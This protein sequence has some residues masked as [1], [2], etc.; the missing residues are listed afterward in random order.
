MRRGETIVRSS[1]EYAILND[2]KQE[3]ITGI[4]TNHN[5]NQQTTF[6]KMFVRYLKLI[7]EFF[8]SSLEI[9]SYLFMIYTCIKNPGI[10]TLVYPLS[11]FGYALMEETRPSKH[12]WYFIMLY[13]QILL[14]TEFILSLNFWHSIFST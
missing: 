3:L 13:T 2:I 9:M 10:V 7:Q 12:Y 1:V 5:L 4:P 11:V 8:Q 6:F 14:I